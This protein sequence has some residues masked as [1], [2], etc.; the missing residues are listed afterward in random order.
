MNNGALPAAARAALTVW[1]AVFALAAPPAAADALEADVLAEALAGRIELERDAESWFWRAGGERYRLLRGEPEEWL[2]LGTP[3]GPLRARWSLLELDSERGLAGLPALLERAA[4]EGVG[5]ENLWL[6]SDGLLGLHLSGPQIYVLPEAVLRAEAVAADGR[7]DERAIARLR[8]AVSDFETPLEGSSLNTAARR[9]LAG[10]LGQLAL[11]D[12]ESDPDYAPPD[13]VR[14]L[15]RHGWPPP[16]ELPAAE[17]G[18][19]R[20]AVIEAEK[21]R[22]VARFR[23]PAGELTLRRDAFGREVRLLRT[24]GRSAYARP[25]PPPAY[26]TPVRSL[27]LVVELPPGADPL[28]DAGDWRAA[29]VFSGP[30]RIAGFAGGRFHADAERW[31]GVYSGGDE[32]GALAGA[33]PP[34]LRV[35]EPNGDLLA[36]VTAHGVV[37][38]AR[39]GDPA[40]AER[41]L[42]QAARAL[43]DA[44]HLDLIGEHLL[45]YA[46]DSPD[47]RHPRLLGTRQLAGDIHQTV[48]QTLATYSG[49][50]YRGDCDDLSE[51]Y[52]EIARR[53]GRSAHL[54]GLPAHAALAWS[55]ASDSGWRTYV[56]HT[57]QPRVFQAP[58]LRESLEQTY[59]SFGAGPVIDFTKLEILL[60]FSGE[61]TRSSWYL[62]ERI[63]GDPDYARAMIDIQRDWHFQTYQR[64]IEKVERMIAAGDRDPA[65]HSELAGLYLQTGRYAEAAGSL[66]RAIAAA[67]SAQTRLSLQTERLLAL[68]RAG[69]RIDA[70]LLADS[71][72]LEHIPELERAMR[73][74]LVEP[75]LAQADALLDAD[76]DAERALALLA[77]DVRPTIDGQVRR[78]GASLASDPKFAA[79]WR[80]GLEDERRTRLRWYVSSAL[81]A[82]ARVD[83]AALRNRAPRRLL[84]ESVERWMDRVAFLDLDPSESLLA[85]Y[86]AVG[87]YYRAR[88]DRPELEQRV[89]AA[90]PPR[91]LEAPLHARRTSGKALFERDLAWIAASPS[92][93]WA[94]VALLFEASREELDVG[95]LAWLAE[96][97]ERARGRAR[98]LA[99]DHPDFERLERNLRLIEALVGQRPAELRRLLRGVG[100]A[101]DRRDR[102]EVA[103]WVAAAARHLPLDWYREV[104]EI[105]SREIGSKPSYFWIAWIAVL[106]GAPEHALVTAEIAAR[107]FADDRGFAQEYEFMRRKFGPEGAARGPL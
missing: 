14:R 91:P 13:F 75:R 38:P 69:R 81:E 98:S 73:R 94:E 22:A 9:A 47:S 45:V 43:P 104:I 65:N 79:R 1:M 90:G 40:E 49:G 87:R 66:E 2:E 29:W 50:V 99:M 95:R 54:I 85:R 80:D 35:V 103:S 16:A 100:L 18:E 24:P 48:A 19:L 21:L 72:R 76:G 84:L 105:W 10:I 106:S 4:R 77:S 58:S 20:A 97:F 44:A 61:N 8:R 67:D 51:L 71:I 57:G 32:P 92:H 82:V 60:R 78:V 42:N 23:G 64:A 36:L 15:F 68:Y 59:R 74:K 7:R 3:H 53:Q 27:R 83:A 93:W 86:A 101:D 25:A 33:L 5:L 11:R 37:R 62:S 55:E 52:L 41:F 70:G 89:D 12:S 28:R 56:L 31:R 26:Y 34:H 17:L 88:G 63:F 30:N 102:T 107:E 46:Y 6:D 96:R 39:G